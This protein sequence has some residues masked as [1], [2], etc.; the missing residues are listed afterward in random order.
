MI[1]I[2]KNWDLDGYLSSCLI[3]DSM[4]KLHL[5]VY[6]IAVVSYKKTAKLFTSNQGESDAP[7]ASVA[8]TL[9]VI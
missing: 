9:Q 5:N 6:K 4:Y 7:S 2:P 8:G 3:V 1:S